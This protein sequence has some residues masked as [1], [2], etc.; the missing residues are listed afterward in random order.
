MGFRRSDLQEA[1]FV[2]GDRAFRVWGYSTT[3]LLEDVLRPGYFAASGLVHLGELIYLRMQ[4]KRCCQAT[5]LV[6]A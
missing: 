3:D 6:G 1:F 2:P 4:R 5:R